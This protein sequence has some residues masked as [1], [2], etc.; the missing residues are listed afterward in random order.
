[1]SPGIKEHLWIKPEHENLD[2]R[3]FQVGLPNIET[4][5]YSFPMLYFQS[6]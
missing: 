2:E 4:T 3:L 5:S 6:K 1:M